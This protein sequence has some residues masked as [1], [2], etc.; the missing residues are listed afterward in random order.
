[1]PLRK[2][3]NSEIQHFGKSLLI[4]GVFIA[5]LSCSSLKR[6]TVISTWENGKTKEKGKLLAGKKDGFWEYYAETGWLQRREKWKKGEF[7]W[8]FSFDE[9]HR[10][11]EMTDKNGN[12]KPLKDCGCR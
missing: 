1:M 5:L 2:I 10:K 7:Q 8:S 3:N 12:T 9:R 11:T 4:F 6:E